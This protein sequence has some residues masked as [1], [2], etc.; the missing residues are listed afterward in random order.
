MSSM[1]FPWNSEPF[2]TAI[3]AGTGHRT[4]LE[5]AAPYCFEHSGWTG[6]MDAVQEVQNSKSE[7][8]QN[9]NQTSEFS[10]QTLR[11]E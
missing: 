11:L 6:E 10:L 7:S 1:S 8:N 9:Q 3:R 2:L 5:V 4:A